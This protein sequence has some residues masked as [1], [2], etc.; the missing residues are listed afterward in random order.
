[1]L[2]IETAQNVGIDQPVASAT[3][4]IFGGLLDGLVILVY[5]IVA[6]FVAGGLDLFGSFALLSLLG[7]PI[8]LYHLICEIVFDGQSFGKMAA[9]TRVVSMDG[10]QATV[11]QYAIRWLLRLVEVTLTSGS[12]ALWTIVLNGRGQRLGD[13]AAGTAVVRVDADPKLAD[14]LTVT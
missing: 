5:L 1:M 10:G 2:R 11:G 3:Q 8:L 4:R 9:K 12:L 6:L 7:L 13:I 14:T